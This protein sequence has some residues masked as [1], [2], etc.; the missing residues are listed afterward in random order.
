MHIRHSRPEDL[1]RM[2]ELYAG[3]RAFMAANGNP[4]QWPE[5]FP[6]EDTLKEDIAT[7]ISYVCEDDGGRVVGTFAFYT[8]REEADYAEIFDGAWL[9]DAPYGVV[10]RITSDRSTHGVGSFCLQWCYDQCGNVRIDTHR[11]NRP[12]RHTLEKNGF[13]QCGIVYV[14]DHEERIAFQKTAG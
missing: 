7:G 11:D 6:A 12:M 10:H 5:G 2:Q 14:R 13:T 9:N 3:A 4:T 8:G 1:P